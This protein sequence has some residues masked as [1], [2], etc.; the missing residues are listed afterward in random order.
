MHG[1]FEHA[2]G[3]LEAAR[4]L[5]L[6]LA[7]VRAASANELLVRLAGSDVEL[8][9]GRN[10]AAGLRRWLWLAKSDLVRSHGAKVVDLRFAGM[11]VLRDLTKEGCASGAS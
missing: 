6:R 8:V 10:A 9:L 2:K 7:S 1:R 5:G 4:G 11:E 3:A